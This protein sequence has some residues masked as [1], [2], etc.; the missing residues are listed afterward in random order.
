M[1]SVYVK[2]N[3]V[4]LD[5][6][7]FLV[8]P[9]DWN[10]DIVTYLAAQENISQVTDSHWKVIRYLRDYFKKFGAAP[11]TRKLCKDTG[12]SIKEIQEMFSSYRIRNAYKLAGLSKPAGCI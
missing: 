12:F 11:M 6:D 2:G 5:A 3:K 1:S 9:E 4:E 7:G 10:E 8:N